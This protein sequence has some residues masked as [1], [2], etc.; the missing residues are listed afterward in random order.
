MFFFVDY[1]NIG[2]FHISMN[3]NQF[4]LTKIEFPLTKKTISVDR[5][6]ISRRK[7]NSK[8]MC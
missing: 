6:C 8:D 2:H 4:P 7:R 1:V 5:N 3:E